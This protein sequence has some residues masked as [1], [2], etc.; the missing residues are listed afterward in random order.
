LERNAI[1][2]SRLICCHASWGG[3][4]QEVIVKRDAILATA[5]TGERWP[6]T[7]IIE[8]IFEIREEF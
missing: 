5:M 8:K 4:E 1:N 7:F 2:P 6:M 3:S